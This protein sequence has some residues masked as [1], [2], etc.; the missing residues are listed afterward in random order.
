MPR[1]ALIGIGA[2]LASAVASLAFVAGVPFALVFVYLSPLP[3]MAAGLA[4]GAKITA[5]G[6]VAGL[7]AT[8]LGGGM[9]SM[10]IF[11]VIQAFPAVLV[12]YLALLRRQAAETENDRTA[13]PWY[14]PGHIAAHLGALGGSL[15][16]LT[17]VFAADPGLS[18]LIS[19]H[20]GEA[21]GM[22]APHLPEE[23]RQR[24][25]MMLAP[26][27]PGAV[28][29]SWAVMTVINGVVAQ[30]LVV[31]MGKNLRPRPVY[32]AIDLPHWLSWPLI[33]AA[34]MAL[35]GSGEWEYVGRN[36][37]IVFATPYFLLGLAVVHGLARR[38]TYTGPLLAVFYLVIVVSLWAALVVAGIGVAE[39][40]IGLRDRTQPP[41][42][43]SRDSEDD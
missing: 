20:L 17:A 41:S 21:F 38:V 7:V 30:G 29:A 19:I 35:A 16:I 36:A 6:A 4:L 27:F 10:L 8:G 31:R 33:G 32:S 1:E 24:F 40:W 9:A 12:V 26:L 34:A 37:A 2:G 13:V 23:A 15:L 42:S 11:G 43:Q 28:A 25:A 14:P 3:L 22:M 5:I 18:S 39:Q